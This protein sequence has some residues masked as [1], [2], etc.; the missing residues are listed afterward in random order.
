[1]KS[2]IFPEG[3][4]RNEEGMSEAEYERLALE[5][6]KS[7]KKTGAQPVVEGRER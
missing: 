5:F 2:M 6:F 4:V 1:M 3:A 7:H